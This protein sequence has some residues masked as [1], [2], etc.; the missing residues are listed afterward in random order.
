[1]DRLADSING[2]VETM[3]E[4]GRI[5]TK[6]AIK[7]ALPTLGEFFREDDGIIYSAPED[8]YPDEDEYEDRYLDED[9]DEPEVVDVANYSMAFEDIDAHD[10]NLLMAVAAWRSFGGPGDIVTQHPLTGIT[11]FGDGPD[12]AE[13]CSQKDLNQDNWTKYTSAEIMELDHDPEALKA[14]MEQDDDEDYIE[15]MESALGEYEKFHWGDESSTT[16][17]LNIPGLDGSEP[18]FF[19]GVARELSFEDDP[20]VPFEKE[21][22]SDWNI[23]ILGK[24][25]PAFPGVYGLGNNVLVLA[26]GELD[27]SDFEEYHEDRETLVAGAL[28]IPGMDPLQELKLLG[29]GREICYGAKKNGTFVEYFHLFGEESD[30]YPGVYALDDRYLVIIGG[31]MHIEGRGI[32]D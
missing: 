19:L 21:D 20:P 22:E 31:N 18:I 6:N 26:G 23:Y 15:K 29:M 13:F 1:M 8:T 4:A 28:D 27:T 30:S 32:V 3:S 24:D 2:V 9:E 12:F 16:G 5:E 25:A 7:N 14:L 11:F 17:I 10:D